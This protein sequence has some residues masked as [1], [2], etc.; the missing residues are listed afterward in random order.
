MS[1]T[2]SSRLKK[3]KAKM[4]DYGFIRLDAWISPELQKL[5]DEERKPC[6]CYGLTLER[7]LF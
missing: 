5:L 4:R 2:N 1:T 3:Y 6:E 7:L